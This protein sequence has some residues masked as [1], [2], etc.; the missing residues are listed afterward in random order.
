M[1]QLTRA[2]LAFALTMGV[3]IGLAAANAVETASDEETFTIGMKN[4]LPPA[5][6]D[7]NLVV[8]VGQP[9][10]EAKPQPI[11][12]THERH[13]TTLGMDCNYCHSNARKG[14]SAGVP[15]TSVCMGCHALI[16]TTDRPELVKLKDYWAKGEVIP[17]E[18]VHDLPDY[19]YFSHKRHVIAGLDCQECHGQ[20][21][22]MT[23]NQRVSSLKMGWCLDCHAQ[24]PSIDENYG[25]KA[26][27]RRA[28]LKDCWT[29]HK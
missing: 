29:C 20:V 24:H 13:V 12:F 23:V 27:L 21:Q 10:P 15:A 16:D 11:A 8:T 6:F 4:L 5:L 25:T 14:V 7:D 28:E 1:R 22:D 3:G 17:W 2:T 9:Q 26:E 18:K 19:V